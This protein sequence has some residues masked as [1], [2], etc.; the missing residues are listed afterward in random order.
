MFICLAPIHH[1]AKLR[2]QIAY[3][4]PWDLES[5]LWPTS[6]LTLTSPVNISPV[7]DQPRAEYH[8]ATRD[9]IWSPNPPTLFK[10]AN[11]LFLLPCLPFP[12]ETP[13]KAQGWAFPSFP[14]CCLTK[15][16]SFPCDNA[17][18]GMSCCLRNCKQYSFFNG[19][20]ISKS[21]LKSPSWI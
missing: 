9:H 16:V 7:P 11:Q 20:S 8:Q 19:I 12:L 2:L 5:M 14:F 4:S 10:R 6:S 13:I 18:H 1:R 15:P 17:W 21:S 3:L